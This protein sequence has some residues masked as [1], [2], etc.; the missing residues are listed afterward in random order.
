MPTIAELLKDHTSL[1]VESFDRLYL[2]GYVPTLQTPG[3]LVSFLVDHHGY[4]IPSPALLGRMTREYVASV[5]EM[6]KR[7]GIPRIAFNRGDRKDDVANELRRK[8][9]RR[10]AV[11]FVGVAQEKAWAFKGQKQGETH[12]EYSRQP[13]FVNHCYFYL[14]DEEFGPAFIK[15]CSYLPYPI[16]VCLNGHEWLKRQLEHRGIGYQSLDNGFRECEDPKFLQRR[17]DELGSREIER[18]FRKWVGRLPFPLTR[19]DRA[20]GYQHD[21]SVWQMEYSITHI[22]D[23][24]QRGREFFEEVIRENLDL[25]RS[26]RV[27]LLFERRVTKATPGPFRTRVITSGVQPSLHIDYKKTEVKQYFKE[28]A[29]LRGE[30]TIR[31]TRDFGIGRR[32]ENLEYLKTIARNINHRLL[33]VEKVSQNCVLSEASVQRLTQPTVTEDG[34]RAPGLKFGD[35]RVMSLMAALSLFVHVANGFRNEDL[36]RLMRELMGL[37]ETEYTPGQMTYDLRRLRLKGLV[38]RAPGTNRYFL[39]PYGWKVSLFITKLHARLFRP[40]FAALEPPEGAA[41]PHP[42]RHALASVDKEIERMLESAR[43]R[44]VS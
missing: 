26:D 27:Q 24:P 16:R 44:A 29:G 15:I 43:L 28:N 31:N 7:E 4:R 14:D 5:E 41:V 20:A 40:G 42:L 37:D 10:D 21:L 23:R 33:E 30:T 22:F 3:Q 18:F 38:S 25:G 11:I 35:P 32:L 1:V 12:F 13:V 36:R 9:P 6:I 19:K 39:T 34:Q 2:N 8:H 17:A